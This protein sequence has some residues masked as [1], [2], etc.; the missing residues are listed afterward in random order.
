MPN[1]K[2]HLTA[3]LVITAIAIKTLTYFNIHL[4]AIQALLGTLS[5]L[6]GSIFPD[7]DTTSKM[8][9][10]FYVAA[11]SIILFSLFIQN[12]F[13]FIGIGISSIFIVFLHHRQLTH[14]TWFVLALPLS[15]AGYLY[16]YEKLPV[17]LTFFCTILFSLGAI[18]HI[19]LDLAVTK[20]HGKRR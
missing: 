4:T 2:V 14:H 5:C 8:Q 13:L 10:L 9:K 7:I 12:W 20:A 15:I 19:I 11:F 1:Y 3:G 6:L 18:G 16:F 17:K